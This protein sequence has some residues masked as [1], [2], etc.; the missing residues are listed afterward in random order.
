MKLM[1]MLVAGSVL[2]FIGI[3]ATFVEA[4]LGTFD[5]PSLAD[6]HCSTRTSRRPSSRS[7]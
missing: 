2:I 1:I 6:A 4:G 7:S 5:L 3:F